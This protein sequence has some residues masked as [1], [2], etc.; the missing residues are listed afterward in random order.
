MY[1]FILNLDNSQIKLIAVIKKNQENME[2]FN[3]FIIY[4]L[5]CLI[6]Y[7]IIVF[8]K[9]LPYLETNRMHFFLSIN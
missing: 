8:V 1:V 5:N 7:R 4:N 6:P 3:T 9:L 2:T